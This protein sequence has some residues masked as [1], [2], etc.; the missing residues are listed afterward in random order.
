MSLKNAVLDSHAVIAFLQNEA[1]A[2]KLDE[3][4]EKAA[5]SQPVFITSVN[6]GE[7]KY[8][9]LRRRGPE[10]WALAAEKLGTLPIAVV[11][12]DR[13]LAEAAADIK[14][15]KNLGYAD[16]FAAALA[17]ARRADLWTGDRD[18]KLVESK[19]HIVWL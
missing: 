15:S 8:Q 16:C 14:A 4:F 6:W 13:E 19:V 12:A 18:F 17:K 5:T 9:M 10:G 2:E 11:A 7:V 1:G 3:L